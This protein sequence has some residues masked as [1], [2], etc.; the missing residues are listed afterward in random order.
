MSL[1]AGVDAVRV[2]FRALLDGISDGMNIQSD[3]K[4]PLKTALSGDDVN[5]SLLSVTFR[6]KY[7]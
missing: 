4:I 3:P 6:L 7:Q 5:P 1:L 2:R